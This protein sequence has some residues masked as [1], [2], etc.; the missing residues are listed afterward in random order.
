MPSIPYP[1]NL[2]PLCITMMPDIMEFI[3]QAPGKIMNVSYGTLKRAYGKI[4]NM[5]IPKIPENVAVP[6]KLA[7]CPKRDAS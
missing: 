5:Q 1:L 7:P 3:L 2:V 4:T 6:Q